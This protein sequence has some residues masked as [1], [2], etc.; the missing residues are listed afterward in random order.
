MESLLPI[1]VTRQAVFVSLEPS[2]PISSERLALL[3]YLSQ[4]FNSSLDLDDVLNK[5]ID[6][7]ISVLHAE[8]GF[9][10]LC[11]RGNE[12]VFRAA[13]G[14]GHTTIDDPQLQISRGIVN[15]AIQDGKPVLT[16]NA[17]M[18]SRFSGRQ[19]VNILGL[20]SILCAPLMVRDRS[21][22]A[23]YVENRLQAGIF[24]EDDLDL[25][26]AISSTAAIAIENARLYQV[27][28]EK[29]RMERELQLARQV[30]SSFIPGESPRIPGWEIAAAW[31]PAREVAGDFYDF[32]QS[33]G[34]RL[35]VV[36]ADVADKGMPAALFM[37]NCRSALRATMLQAASI[38][39]GIT[40]VNR[41]VCADST[42]GMF[43]TL[44]YAQIDPKTGQIDFV[45]GGH[46][47]P[48]LYRRNG[49]PPAE[50]NR[51]GMALG[52][53]PGAPYQAGALRLGAGD[54]LLLYTDG[55]TDA[56]NSQEAE[57]GLPRLLEAAASCR[58]DSA[59]GVVDWIVS[60][61]NDFTGSAEPFD[62]ITLVVIKRL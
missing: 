17:Q 31:I 22:G 30:Q 42:S 8:R 33:D 35:N 2:S 10:V 7:I 15:Q 18:D 41:A 46:N 34:G 19:S 57:F 52:V 29:G 12:L 51:T 28:V 44:F 4:T 48:L 45:N 27:A 9:V 56:I 61:I 20:T 16:S 58:Q 43:L 23:V 5:V 59:Q 24:S 13:R 53:E 25:L 11:E 14:M 38:T 54:T 50:L 47:P 55:L 40:N 36:I 1:L 6:E 3:Y 49:S 32:F 60:T 21:L 37:A 39:E 62:D 26:G